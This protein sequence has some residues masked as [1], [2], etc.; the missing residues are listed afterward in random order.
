MPKLVI[1]ITT[2]VAK[3]KQTLHR[4]FKSSQSLCIAETATS[5]PS[6]MPEAI[7]MMGHPPMNIFDNPVT[8]NN[9]AKAANKKAEK[10]IN[11]GNKYFFMTYFCPGSRLVCSSDAIL[12]I[13]MNLLTVLI[14]QS[15]DL[16][17][18]SSVGFNNF[19]C[20]LVN[21]F[22]FPSEK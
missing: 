16:F 21:L 4:G 22:G 12:C 5:L 3:I 6:S 7:M 2:T 19:L 14:I 10:A 13:S 8:E 9:A 15:F 1:N 17:F 11:A 20:F 18:T